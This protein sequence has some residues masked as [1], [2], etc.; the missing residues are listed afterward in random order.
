VLPPGAVWTVARDYASATT[1]AWSSDNQPTGSWRL[2][3]WVRQSGS[4]SAYDAYV[5][6]PFTI[7]GCGPVQLSAL[8]ASPQESGTT[9]SLTASTTGC[10]NPLY[11]FWVADASGSW[12]VVRDYQ[13]STSFNW[14]SAGY[15]PG[16]R[17]VGVWARDQ[18]SGS[19]Y[20]SYAIQ[21][22]SITGCSSAAVTAGPKD[23]QPPGTSVT[24]SAT[25]AGCTHPLYRFWVEDP[26]GNWLILRDYS[27]SATYTY[28]ST[29]AGAGTFHFGVWALDQQSGA[30]YDSWAAIPYWLKPSSWVIPNVPYIRQYRSLDC[31]AASLQMALAH[32]S[33]GVSQD[34]ELN[35]MG[36]DWSKAWYDSNGVLHWGDPYVYF[37]GN[38]DGSEVALTGYGVFYPPLVKITGG[39]GGRVVSAGQNT[40][41]QQVY[42]AVLDNHPVVV[43]IAVDY[44]YHS[45]QLWQANDGRWV[46]Y[47]GPVEHTATVVGVNATQVYLFDPFHGAMW[48]DKST[49]EATYSTYADMALVLD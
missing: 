24:L 46:I 39:Y 1:F 31:E 25:S 20:D 36:I 7:T 14:S 47:A 16:A 15:V 3:V 28:D 5:I 45:Q 26:Y 6:V 43:W 21:P 19:L 10:A 38:P 29:G 22:Y 49:F 41:P 9:V 18:H 37:V 33:I 12:T 27:T 2:G 30:R 48:V 8:P 4:T 13:A 11:R 44:R 35:D 34:Q 23:P 42:D 32:E 17:Q 40:T